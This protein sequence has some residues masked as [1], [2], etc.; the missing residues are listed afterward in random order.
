MPTTLL[1]VEYNR[2]TLVGPDAVTGTEELPYGN[3]LVAATADPP[4]GAVILTGLADGQV[5]V[6]ARL[7]PSAPAVPL[8]NWQD[9]AIVALRWPGGPMRLLGADVV[10]PSALAFAPDQPPGVYGLLVAGRHRDDG[11]TRGT[12]DPVEEYLI[13]LWPSASAEPARLLKATSETGAYW[14]QVEPGRRTP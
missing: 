9:A 14:R 10:P 8:D 7:L 2:F 3:G 11:E 13:R 12:E 4:G 1:W 6:T 5:R